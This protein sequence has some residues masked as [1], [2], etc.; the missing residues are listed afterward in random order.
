M[1]QALIYGSLVAATGILAWTASALL[2]RRQ[3]RVKVSEAQ[4]KLKQS[5][6]KFLH[7]QSE[8]LRVQK[9]VQSLRSESRDKQQSHD[10]LMAE[11]RHGLTRQGWQR[12]FAG[13]AFGL[14][15]GGFLVG[16]YGTSQAR[17]ETLQ[18]TADLEV[19]A[20]VA[21]A[22]LEL[23][24]KNQNEL[25]KQ[26]Q[27]LQLYSM[28]MR[29]INAVAMTKMNILLYHIA[30]RKSSKLGPL[31][32]EALRMSLQMDEGGSLKTPAEI[33]PLAVKAV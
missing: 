7:Y 5:E 10:I 12:A 13:L 29:E 25:Q 15:A 18:A 9:E 6:A 30:D 28:E 32:I 31:D 19:R 2:E 23:M 4:Q 3:S 17:L 20:R 14:L 8:F 16:G 27:E 33:L 22:K 1:I 21:E 11:T 24:V 26:L